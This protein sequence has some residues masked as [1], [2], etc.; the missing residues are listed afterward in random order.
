MT[1]GVKEEMVVG[2]GGLRLFIRTWTP[3]TAARAAV[4]ICPG[5]NSHS[6]QYLWVAEQ[7]AAAGLA[8]YAV[9]LRG[10]G[11][12]DGERFH[13]EDVQTYVGDLSDLVQRAKDDNPGLPLFLLG[14]SAGGVISSVYCLE[15]QDE[16]A[17]LICESFAFRVPAPDLALKIIKGVSHILPDTPILKLKNEDFSRDPAVVAALNADP[18]IQNETQPAITVAA[19]QRAD[20][21]LARE[22][23][24]ITLPVLILHGT[25]DKATLP[26]GSQQFHDEAGSADKTL[27]L[28]EG[29]YHDL[30]ADYGKAEVMADIQAWIDARL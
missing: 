16:L 23:G 29:H 22:F 1:I 11:R 12:S 24:K 4:V 27:K 18:L 30:L 15:H 13:I 19:L 2:A 6:G 8:V 17:G 26:K 9:D 3:Q 20:E 7:F 28:Y 21:R 5:F 14:H 10:R 25:A